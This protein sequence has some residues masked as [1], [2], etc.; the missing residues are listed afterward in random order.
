M[1][2]GQPG[3]TVR[4]WACVAASS[5]A[6][7]AEVTAIPPMPACQRASTSGT[8]WIVPCGQT[9]SQAS[10]AFLSSLAKASGSAS[11]ACRGPVALQVEAPAPTRQLPPGRAPEMLTSGLVPPAEGNR[12]PGTKTRTHSAR[13]ASGSGKV[14]QAEVADHRIEGAVR[15]GQRDNL[16]HPEF[17]A[18]LRPLRQRDHA[19]G[20]IHTS[21]CSPA[22]AGRH[23]SQA[24]PS[25]DIQHAPPSDYPQ[26]RPAA[27]PVQGW[28]T[29]QSAPRR[30]RR[31]GH[32]PTIQ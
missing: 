9:S 1:D 27:G 19:W 32:V 12:P 4:A 26:Q 17:N 15:E 25:G 13:A 5:A 11:E 18:G 20:D 21:G 24:G 22:D 28:S 14:A 8:R 3:T 30:S 31:Y 10:P 16:G 7:A 2:L 23:G 29:A 6:I